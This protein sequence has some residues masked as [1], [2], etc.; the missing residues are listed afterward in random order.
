MNLS[1]RR[2][3]TDPGLIIFS[4][5]KTGQICYETTRGSLV[6]DVEWIHITVNEHQS[7]LIDHQSTKERTS[8]RIVFYNIAFWFS[9]FRIMRISPPRTRF[10]AV[11]LGEDREERKQKRNASNRNECNTRKH[12][13]LLEQ[14]QQRSQSQLA[15]A[16]IL[17]EA[18]GL[19]SY[20]NDHNNNNHPV[21]MPDLCSGNSICCTKP[22]QRESMGRSQ[23][24]TN[25]QHY[26]NRAK[27]PLRCLTLGFR[28]SRT[29]DGMLSQ[30]GEHLASQSSSA[31]S[32]SAASSSSTQQK[33]HLNTKVRST[34]TYPTMPYCFQSILLEQP[35][36]TLSGGAA[37]AAAAAAASTPSSAP[38][39]YNVARPSSMDYHHF[40]HNHTYEDT[41]SVANTSVSPSLSYLERTRSVLESIKKEKLQRRTAQFIHE[42][43]QL[44]KRSNYY[45]QKQNEK[46]QQQQQP[47]QPKHET[48]QHGFPKVETRGKNKTKEHSSDM[49]AWMDI[50]ANTVDDVIDDDEPTNFM[51]AWMD[52]PANTI[53]DV[54]N[55][56]EKEATL[57]TSNTDDYSEE[58]PHAQLPSTSITEVS[59]SDGS[60]T[61]DIP[62]NDHNLNDSI[63]PSR[64]STPS[65]TAMGQGPLS[66]RVLKAYQS[67]TRRSM[68][69]KSNSTLQGQGGS[70]SRTRSTWKSKQEHSSSEAANQQQATVS[71]VANEPQVSSIVPTHASFSFGKTSR[72]DAAHN[73]AQLLKGKHAKT[74]SLSMAAN[75]KNA[76][77]DDCAT[78]KDS[79]V[80][81]HIDG[82][83]NGVPT[84]SSTELPSNT[85]HQEA[86][87]SS[88]NQYWS[89]DSHSNN[90]TASSVKGSP[91]KQHPMFEK[92]MISS[93]TRNSTMMDSFEE[94]S[95]AYHSP[96]LRTGIQLQSSNQKPKSPSLTASRTLK[97]NSDALKGP[98]AKTNARV[99]PLGEGDN[100][101]TTSSSFGDNDSQ[102]HVRRPEAD[103]S[104]ESQVAPLTPVRSIICQQSQIKVAAAALRMSPGGS[105]SVVIE[106]DDL[107]NPHT[108]DNVNEDGSNLERLLCQVDQYGEK[109]PNP[110]HSQPTLEC[111]EPIS[112]ILAGTTE[113]DRVEKHPPHKPV[114]SLLCPYKADQ[115]LGNFDSKTS[116]SNIEEDEYSEFDS[117]DSSVLKIH[118]DE[119][120]ISS[121]SNPTFADSLL[122]HSTSSPPSSAK[123]PSS[124]YSS[125]FN[126][127]LHDYLHHMELFKDNQLFHDS[128]PTPDQLSTADVIPQLQETSCDT[129]ITR[130]VNP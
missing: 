41:L 48:P 23:H 37:A 79:K 129:T 112:S 104:E 86:E 92:S 107:I 49:D 120:T 70:L 128:L 71:N 130:N 114:R 10:A 91:T 31:A 89:M 21:A 27:S 66:T 51:D 3:S 26:H 16:K 122:S 11:L 43:E 1:R 98:K 68:S 63:L 69:P 5:N 12:F 123:T 67:S 6:F 124:K 19:S 32:V 82:H 85:Q 24:N 59:N 83:A 58:S 90:E 126:N 118:H 18:A 45:H 14:H 53:D 9:I 13:Q 15:K 61:V 62:I 20:D 102:N 76:T 121:L 39:P 30:S 46:L 44:E 35:K 115:L 22:L 42:Q 38:S 93:S 50:P 8:Y 2:V 106:K 111:F 55:G 88:E 78:V 75:E 54:I 47:Q 65:S 40:Q 101:N 81:F 52:V 7:S 113:G 94:R 80:A 110:Q 87:K 105:P 57:N 109:K 100:T 97:N 125:H 119:S 29:Q 28:S 73:K 64:T 72:A 60:S 74:S 116:I 95:S 25:K 96:K 84:A 77:D 127:G 56:G 34:K 33:Q 117:Q 17:E 99:L 4:P 108:D 103:D 36:A